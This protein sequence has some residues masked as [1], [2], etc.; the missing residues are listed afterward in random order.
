[1]LSLLICANKILLQH[2]FYDID[3]IEKFPFFIR[4]PEY[5]DYWEETLHKNKKYI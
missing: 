2:K 4:V 3:F 5:H 1:M